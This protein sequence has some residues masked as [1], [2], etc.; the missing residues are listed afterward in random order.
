M[1]I[2]GPPCNLMI[3]R[4]KNNNGAGQ[5]DRFKLEPSALVD[6]ATGSYFAAGCSCEV[7]AFT[8]TPKGRMHFVGVKFVPIIFE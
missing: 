6:S 1:A 4:S 2:T 7:T 8:T 5:A 3:N